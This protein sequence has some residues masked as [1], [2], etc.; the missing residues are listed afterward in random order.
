LFIGLPDHWGKG[1]GV[2]ILDAMCRFLFE[3][4][5]ARRI[6]IDPLTTNIRAIRAY[7]KSGFREWKTVPRSQKHGGEWRDTLVMV[8][9]RSDSECLGSQG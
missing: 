8:R 5:Q 3:E 6:I 4:K 1:W 2:K 9:T 7:R